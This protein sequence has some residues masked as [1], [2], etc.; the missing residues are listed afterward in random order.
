MS[1]HANGEVG[2]T[3]G[4]KGKGK[5]SSSG[6]DKSKSTSA[7]SGRDKPH[8]KGGDKTVDIVDDSEVASPSTDI[9]STE[10]KIMSM[11]VVALA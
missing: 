2:A 7:L 5:P 6:K 9:I 8:D 10:Y 3:S 1:S 4:S 11:K